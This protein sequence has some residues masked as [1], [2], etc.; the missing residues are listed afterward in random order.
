MP[1]WNSSIY[2]VQFWQYN[3]NDAQTTLGFVF[4]PGI[5]EQHTWK[6]KKI[7]LSE[8]EQINE[9]GVWETI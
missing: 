5:E 2:I 4:D 1:F 8:M 3:L 9:L 6:K 7:I